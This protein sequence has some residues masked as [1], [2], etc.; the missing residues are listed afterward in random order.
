MDIAFLC[1]TYK[2]IVHE[3]TKRWLK[4]KPVYINT[5]EP[6]D[7][8]PYTVLS[9]PTEWGRRSIVDATLAL[10]RT[11][12]ANQHEWYMLL[13]HDAYPIVTYNALVK[14]ITKSMFHLMEQ[15]D[16]GTEWKASQWWCLS[17]Q[18]VGMILERHEEYDAYVKTFPYQT[19]GAV[20]ELYFL[21]CLKFLQPTYTYLDKKTIYVD[22]L[23]QSIQKHPVEYGALLEGDLDRM[24]DSFFLRK[25]TPYFTPTVHVPKH[26]LVVQVFGDKSNT[27]QDT[28]AD[29]I[30]ISITKNIPDELLKRSLRI[31]YTFYSNLERVIREVLDRIPTYLWKDTIV[32]PEVSSRTLKTLPY[33]GTFRLDTPYRYKQPKIAFLFLTIGDVHQPEVWTRYFEGFT[34][35]YSVFSHPKFP[36]KVK[37]PWLR[38]ALIPERVD[39]GW[40]YITRAYECLF[41]EAM[42]DPDNI[43]FIT[44]SESCIP[45]KHFQPFYEF[46]KKMDERT[47]YVR[48]MK[49]SAYDQHARIETQPHY[50]D[51]PFFQK[52]YARMCLSRYHVQK[53]L[54]SPDL[55]FFH[56]M[57]VGDEFFLSS[58]GIQPNVDFVKPFEITYDNWKD[59][60]E[61]VMKLKEENRTLGDSAFEKDLY[62][63]NKVL[64]E[65]IG[66]NPK[67]YTTITTDEIETALQQESFFWRKFTTGPL[68]WTAGILSILPKKTRRKTPSHTKTR[69]K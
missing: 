44:I 56:T 10:L 38:D 53:V 52:H 67:T 26:T 49:L 42:K 21:S 33:S 51:I 69:R 43:Q 32:M 25:T 55:D 6:I 18:D 4:G 7:K 14:Q 50:Q 5:K 54:R 15:N 27:I 61:R 34:G 47:S 40:G 9:I 60:A 46:L 1:L 12:H 24:K 8:T 68:P 65:D 19:R 29:I 28:G 13:S 39:T 45:L 57:H 17:K 37:T 31:Y 63:R 62:R 11:A 64:Q 22:W 36:E 3:K 41:R 23:S 35:K 59:T 20:D 2:G 30:L 16:L 66:K 58:I 48:F